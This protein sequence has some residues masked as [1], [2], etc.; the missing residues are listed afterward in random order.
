[1]CIPFMLLKAHVLITFNP[2]A[3]ASSIATETSVMLVRKL[4]QYAFVP[5][6]MLRSPLVSLL[7]LDCP[8]RLTSVVIRFAI[9]LK[10]SP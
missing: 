2:L 4:N 1:M 5:S 9:E 8:T 3:T 7:Q 10:M 6:S